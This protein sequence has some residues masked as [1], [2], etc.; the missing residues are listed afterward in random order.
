M[1]SEIIHRIPFITEEDGSKISE[2]NE[3]IRT[4]RKYHINNGKCFYFL[5][6]REPKITSTP[7]LKMNK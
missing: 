4:I 7:T 1:L 2:D 3:T 5:Y 6:F